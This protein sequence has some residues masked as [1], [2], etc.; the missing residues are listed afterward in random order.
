MLTRSRA[1]AKNIKYYVNYY[2]L[3]GDHQYIRRLNKL[4]DTQP[5]QIKYQ[6]RT[7]KLNPHIMQ[8]PYPNQQ[9]L[10]L[11]NNTYRPIDFSNNYV[12]IKKSKIIEDKQKLK[13][14]NITY[15][16]KRVQR[17]NYNCSE[18]LDSATVSEFATA[19]SKMLRKKM[20]GK[21]WLVCNFNIGYRSS[22]TYDIGEDI[23]AYD[24]NDF[25]IY[26][27]NNNEV[28][29]DQ[30]VSDFYLIFVEDSKSKAGG[31]S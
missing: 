3:S 10:E 6:N 2:Y 23:Q 14:L 28:K 24:P 18:A 1:K 19:F 7:F 29:F 22:K 17:R 30:K 26:N 11:G 27:Q 16:G 9:Y 8:A 13:F 15:R 31:N 12:L 5:V 21:L 20:Q 25:D 4:A